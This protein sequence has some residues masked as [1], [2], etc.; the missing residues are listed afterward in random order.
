MEKN[1]KKNG[2]LIFPNIITEQW[3]YRER[4]NL[5]LKSNPDQVKANELKCVAEVMC[6][7]CV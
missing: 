5:R 4:N 6:N 2:L 1:E 7:Y 3:G